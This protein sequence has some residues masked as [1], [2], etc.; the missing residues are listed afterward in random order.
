MKMT[1]FQCVYVCFVGCL[2]MIFKTKPPSTTNSSSF[3]PLAYTDWEMDIG[4]YFLPSC[5]IS[6]KTQEP[7]FSTKTARTSSNL[8][9]FLDV[10]MMW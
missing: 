10:A 1:F 5:S 9:A 7:I 3:S 6:W 4:V 8:I 2:Y